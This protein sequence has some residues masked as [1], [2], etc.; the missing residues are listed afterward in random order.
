MD[1]KARVKVSFDDIFN[2]M[3]NKAS[4]NYDNIHVWSHTKWSSQRIGINFSYRFGKTNMK[5]SRQRR[6]GLEDES[7]RVGS[8]RQ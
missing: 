7:N 8:G 3:R 6:S 4:A 1:G 5:P 2:T